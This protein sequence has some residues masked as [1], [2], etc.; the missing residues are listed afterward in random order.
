MVGEACVTPEEACVQ[1]GKPCRPRTPR[2]RFVMGCAWIHALA[3]SLSMNSESAVVGVPRICASRRARLRVSRARER[4]TSGPAQR[5]N[6][7]GGDA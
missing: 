4:P 2:T 5:A 7:G 6:K 3:L 1:V